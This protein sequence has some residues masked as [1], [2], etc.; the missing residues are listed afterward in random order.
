MCYPIKISHRVQSQF[1]PGILAV[2]LCWASPCISAGQNS[3]QEIEFPY[4]ALILHEGA[5]L[6][7]GPGNVHYATHRLKRGD[8]VEVFRH[9][10]GGWNAVRPVSGSFSLVPE[11]VLKILGD[12]VGQITEDGTQ[13]WVGTELG[14]VAKPLWQV[15]LKK[16]EIVEVLGKT[17]PPRSDGPAINWYQI[18]PPAGEFR[19]VRMSDIQLP[20]GSSIK[21]NQLQ[22]SQKRRL[23]LNDIVPDN[24]V[25]QVNLQ[26][27]FNVPLRKP[28][29]SY[30]TVSINE[31]WRQATKPIARVNNNPSSGG[32]SGS[33]ARQ[34]S[35]FESAL[36]GMGEAPQPKSPSR[37]ATPLSNSVIR[38]ADASTSLP[39]LARDLNSARNLGSFETYVPGRTSI[40]A[41]AKL[42]DLDFKLTQEML[43]DPSQWQLE[44]LE[45]AANSLYQNASAEN[46]RTQAQKFLAKI[47]NCKT[48]RAGYRTSGNATFTSDNNSG[49]QATGSGLK[50]TSNS[51]TNY[52]A[53]GW[54]SEMVQKGGNANSSFVIQDATGKITHLVTPAPGMN[55][56]PYLKRRIGIIGQL[57]HHARLDLRHVTALRIAALDR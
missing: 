33:T 54:L 15:K 17:S 37:S 4:Q 57:G 23:S 6:H 26:T 53:I 34:L 12:G 27:E 21:A 48:I 40:A 3:N 9:D 42:S 22:S 14:P 32:Y 41:T 20:L 51:G 56:R 50:Q 39:N 35:S 28:D 47:A 24:N 25:S 19:W 16:G 55:L 36:A 13:A 30:R 44:D 31:G 1:L 45:L 43:R 29:A 38:I 7:S 8:A 5:T 49:Y 18:S 46:E 11:T 52:D 10:P 2:I